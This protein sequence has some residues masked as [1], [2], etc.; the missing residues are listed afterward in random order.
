MSQRSNYESSYFCFQNRP[1][2][3]DMKRDK[4]DTQLTFANIFNLFVLHA[5]TCWDNFEPHYVWSGSSDL[6]CFLYVEKK[7]WSI[8]Q[9]Q[10][11]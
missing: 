9:L 5:G 10:M 7:L 4:V 6:L 11:Q 8:L 3:R 2:L 1:D